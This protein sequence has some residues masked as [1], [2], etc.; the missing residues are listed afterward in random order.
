MAEKQ[1][2]LL[3]SKIMEATVF[4]GPPKDTGQRELFVSLTTHASR[5][6]RRLTFSDWIDPVKVLAV[7]AECIDDIEVGR[8]MLFELPGLLDGGLGVLEKQPF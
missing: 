2:G 7:V 1:L 5:S 4:I 8:A 6:Q 3:G